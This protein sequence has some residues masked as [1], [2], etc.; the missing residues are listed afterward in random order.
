MTL[1]L[2]IPDNIHGMQSGWVEI[3][4]DVRLHVRFERMEE[5]QSF[6]SQ[7]AGYPVYEARDFIHIRQPGEMNNEQVRYVKDTDKMRFPRQWEAYQ[8]GLEQTQTG[9][10]LA[11]LF[12]RNPEIVANLK[13][14]R[15]HTIEALAGLSE[16]GIAALGVGARNMV[17]K[18]MAF[19]ENMTDAS[20]I[21]RLQ[22]EVDAAKVAEAIKDQQ[23]ASLMTRLAALESKQGEAA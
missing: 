16:Q 17:Q 15:I 19:L 11:I 18:A 6:K 1:S 5:I 9:M 10:P 12:D 3:G 21:K 2:S 23:M 20:G 22:A 13:S 8:A 7:E 4:S 14:R